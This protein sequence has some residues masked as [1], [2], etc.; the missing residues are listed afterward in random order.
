[1]IVMSPEQTFMVI[2]ACSV[3]AYPLCVG[4][5]RIVGWLR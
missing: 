4:L 5:A 1:M 3:L 2:T